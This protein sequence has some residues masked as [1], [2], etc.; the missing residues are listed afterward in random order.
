MKVYWNEFVGATESP[1]W[2][3][4]VAQQIC[5]NVIK[6]KKVAKELGLPAHYHRVPI[7][8]KPWCKK[9]LRV[10]Y[11]SEIAL[12]RAVCK[13]EFATEVDLPDWLWGARRPTHQAARGGRVSRGDAGAGG[14][15]V[16]AEEAGTVGSDGDAYRGEGRGDYGHEGGA[17][18]QGAVSSST[19]LGR[20][21]WRKSPA[22]P[23]VGDSGAQAG[24]A[25]LD[26]PGRPTE[27]G[28]GDSGDSHRGG[29]P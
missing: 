7:P 5:I 6:I 23:T 15:A 26:V 24:V 3:D 18:P 11:P 20:R 27:S 28:G 2:A 12:I 4:A 17:G 14:Q 25:E 1:V 9:R 21:T 10:F 13:P 19:S 16:D 8:G 22:S 29:E